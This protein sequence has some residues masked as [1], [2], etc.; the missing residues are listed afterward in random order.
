[1]TPAGRRLYVYYRVPAAALAATVVDVRRMQAAL[2]NAH[3]G[4]ATQLLRR[5]PQP[6]AEVTLMEVYA[7]PGGVDAARQAAI[8][9]AAAALPGAAGQAPRHVEVFEDCG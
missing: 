5:P 9:A 4:L 1:M 7:A 8:A 3:P 6:G 2:R